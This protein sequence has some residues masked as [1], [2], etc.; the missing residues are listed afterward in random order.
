MAKL[1]AAHY[2]LP[3]LSESEGCDEGDQKFD[4]MMR[5]QT[6]EIISRSNEFH[7]GNYV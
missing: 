2:E 4:A 7:P 1:R 6:N 3:E 5:L